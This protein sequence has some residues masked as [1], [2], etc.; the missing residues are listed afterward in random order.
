MSLV[1]KNNYQ[2]YNTSNYENTEPVDFP[3]FILT[4]D[5]RCLCGECDYCCGYEPSNAKILYRFDGRR[6][7]VVMRSF[8][9]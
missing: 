6:Y 4:S 3:E 7:R 9:N 5:R 8:D 1:E 2:N